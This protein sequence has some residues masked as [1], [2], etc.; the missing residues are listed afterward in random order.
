MGLSRN[1]PTYKRGKLSG[2]TTKG[3]MQSYE[4]FIAEYK[5]Y[6]AEKAQANAQDKSHRKKTSY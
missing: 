5:Q 3:V 6:K 1:N 2:R 4:D